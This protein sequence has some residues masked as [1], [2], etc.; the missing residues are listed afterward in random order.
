[1]T[2]HSDTANTPGRRRQ[3]G[4]AIVMVLGVLAVA[5]LMVVHIMTVCEVV[6]KDALVSSTRSE[7][8]YQAESGADHAFWMHL[9]DRRLFPSRKLGVDDESRI[10]NT[11]FEPWMAD[12]RAH[13]LFDANCQAYINTIEKTVRIDKPDTFKQYISPED[14]D[15]LETVNDFLDVLTDYTDTNSLT[16]LN[17]KESD[18]YAQEGL[19]S[20]PRDDAMQFMQEIYWLDGW[21]QAVNAEVTIIPPAGKSLSAT[22][23]KPSF[24]SASASEIQTI[25]DITDGELET[26]MDARDKWM[27]DSI[28]IADSLPADLAANIMS[29]FN[30]SESNIA[31]F[32]V[33]SASK[34]GSMRILFNVVREVN[35][36]KNTIFADT[37]SNA[38]SIWSRTVY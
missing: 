32:V 37:S 33:S 31:E 35:L 21:M 19:A 12:R 28:P 2:T 1:M 23:S 26:I 7:L 11:D 18:D 10:S 15:A 29:N 3:K 22:T 34:D 4:M 20:M 25:L 14:T 30:F 24:F 17:G 27:A 13:S 8:R 6:S 36:S 9:T 16:M 5:L 38:F